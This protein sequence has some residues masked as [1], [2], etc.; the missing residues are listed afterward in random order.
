MVPYKRHCAETIE[1]AINSADNKTDVPI[2]ERTHKRIRI[3]WEIVLP[4]FLS[5]LK[6]LSQK[7]NRPYDKAPA[8]KGIVRV[9]V[10]SGHWIFA[11][12]LCTRSGAMSG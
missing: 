1:K 10:N 2:D 3:W 5:I 12:D 6:S 8:F 9:V 7:L 11:N 4:Y